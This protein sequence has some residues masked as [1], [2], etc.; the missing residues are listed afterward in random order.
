MRCTAFPPSRVRYGKLSL[1]VALAVHGRFHAF[2]LARELVRLG[3]D[4]HLFTNYP[5]RVAK[6]FGV[7]PERTSSNVFHGISSRVAQKFDPL[8]LKKRLE[9][10]D[11]RFF[12][13]WAARRISAGTFDVVHGFSGIC[14][15]IFE[16]VGGTSVKTLVRGSAHIDTQADLLEAEEERAGVPLDRPSAWIRAREKREYEAA[17][18]IFVL[19][20]FAWR[21]FVHHGINPHKLRLLSLGSD[22]SRFKSSLE[23]CAARRERILRNK[24]LRILMTGNFS[25]QKGALDL[26]EIARALSR[27]M[28]FIFVGTVTPEARTLAAKAEQY[29][30]FEPRVPQNELPPVYARADGFIFTTVHDGYAVVLAQAQASG[31]PL[32]TTPNCAGP[33]LVEENVTGWVL[34]IRNSAA[35]IE[36]LTM[37][38]R[39]REQLARVADASCRTQHVRD[40]REVAI[41]FAGMQREFLNTHGTSR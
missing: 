32:L 5:R 37:L 1:K 35:F 22:L 36:K 9:P 28:D 29:I 3:E 41:D 21:T 15:E 7:P 38:N 23:I 17:D 25:F 24:R 14:E 39:N 8:F 19:S 34:P 12:S 27:D 31:L 11:L 40:W 10:W 13:R 2:D 6:Q 20:R 16:C 33:E 18:L 30:R 26:V 4:V